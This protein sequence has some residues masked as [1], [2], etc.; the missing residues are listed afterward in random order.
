MGIGPNGAS[1][2]HRE[3]KGLRRAKRMMSLG[4]GSPKMKTMPLPWM[5]VAAAG[6]RLAAAMWTDMLDLGSENGK[7]NILK[8]IK[9]MTSVNGQLVRSVGWG[10]IGT[11]ESHI[12]L[13]ERR[14]GSEDDGRAGRAN[15][16]RPRRP[17]R[18]AAGRGEGGGSGNCRRL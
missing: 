16:A 2:L 8:Q 14:T 18:M 10:G 4:V 9:N 6:S 1:R 17:A 7:G 3:D 5:E 13:A 12:C 15:R 11:S